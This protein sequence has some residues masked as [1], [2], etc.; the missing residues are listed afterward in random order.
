[1]KNPF[2]LLG[3]G[4]LE[5]HR[6]ERHD[7]SF[8][9]F[10]LFEDDCSGALMEPLLEQV[11]A[12]ARIAQETVDALGGGPH[13]ILILL[14][15]LFLGGGGGAR[16]ALS[17]S[18]DERTLAGHDTPHR[19]RDYLAQ[20]RIGQHRCEGCDEIAQGLIQFGYGQ[21]V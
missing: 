14:L 21:L 7:Q 1:L 2:E 11:L 9:G 20:T 5:V 3:I 6:I 12:Q 10:L 19:K 13:R 8:V 4:L 16:H 17:H 18:G 15:F